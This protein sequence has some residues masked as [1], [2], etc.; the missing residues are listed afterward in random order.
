[1]LPYTAIMLPNVAI[2]LPL[3]CSIPS[4]RAGR[5]IDTIG[6]QHHDQM[7]ACLALDQN[8]AF[9]CCHNA[10]IM[11]LD[12]QSHWLGERDLGKAT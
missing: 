5:G 9:S 2:M 10:A 1:M 11:L 3:C 7:P 12:P 6:G 8:I 4:D